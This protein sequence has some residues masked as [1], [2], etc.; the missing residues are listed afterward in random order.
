MK[1]HVKK[2]LLRFQHETP[3]RPQHAPSQWTGPT[4][5]AKIQ[6]AEDEDTSRR[7][8]KDEIKRLQEIV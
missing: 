8:E 3:I 2:A 5:G 6:M 4:Y 1:G 7:L